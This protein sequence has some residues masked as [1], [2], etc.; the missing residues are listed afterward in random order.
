MSLERFQMKN[1]LSCLFRLPQPMSVLVVHQYS[2]LR[3][4][5]KTSLGKIFFLL[6]HRGI[7][8]I[9]LYHLDLTG[10]PLKALVSSTRSFFGFTRPPTKPVSKTSCLP[11]PLNQLHLLLLHQAAQPHLLTARLD[12]SPHRPDHDQ[13][14][15]QDHFNQGKQPAITY[16]RI[17]KQLYQQES[18]TCSD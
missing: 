9:T 6:T 11:S 18:R 14:H 7:L 13:A 2:W 10:S 15:H 1:L 17:Q 4:A 3:G 12:P 16:V 8:N 5:S